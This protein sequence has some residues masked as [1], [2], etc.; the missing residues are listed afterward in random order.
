MLRYREFRVERR[1]RNAEDA[2]GLSFGVVFVP[3]LAERLFPQ[4]LIE[5]RGYEDVSHY[6][7]WTAFKASRNK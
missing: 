5:E 1:L 4:K 7:G 6:G 2:R 3:A